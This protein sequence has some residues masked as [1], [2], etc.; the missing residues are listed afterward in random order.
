M[1]KHV[2]NLFTLANLFC[3]C[4]ATVFLFENNINVNAVTLIICLGI[5][6]DLLDGFLARKL[7]VQSKLGLELDSLADLIT[8]GLVPGIII[9]RLFKNSSAVE[10]SFISTEL[11]AYLAFFITMASAYRLANFN[12]KDSP[13]NFFIGLPVPA[14]TIMIL[15]LLLVSELS[16]NSFVVELIINKYFLISLVIISSFL[17]NS[18]LKFISF[19]F[20]NYLFN[21]E[22]NSRYFLILSSIILLVLLGYIS[23]PLIFLIYFVIS[24]FSLR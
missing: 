20:N 5:F 15:S 10:L 1:I 13:K 16:T 4:L 12:I 17:M 24:I 9:F 2:P 11:I 21:K 7:N 18:N 6:F 23:I 8:S 14:N 19:K 3:G 22:N